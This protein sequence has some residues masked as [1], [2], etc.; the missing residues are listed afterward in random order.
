MLQNRKR[1]Q[2]DLILFTLQKMRSWGPHLL[3]QGYQ[4]MIAQTKTGK[5]SAAAS[6]TMNVRIPAF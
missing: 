5:H 1:K 2:P 6:T 4:N 3:I